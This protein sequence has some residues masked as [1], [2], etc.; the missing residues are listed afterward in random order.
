ME[1]NLSNFIFLALFIAVLV[2]TVTMFVHSL[3]HHI[4]NKPAWA[5]LIFFTG[6]IGALVYYFTEHKNYHTDLS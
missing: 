5:L 1:S 6:F 4:K 3:T 2:F